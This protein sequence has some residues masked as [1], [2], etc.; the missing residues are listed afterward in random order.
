M[1][2][3]MMM[4]MRMMMMMMMMKMKMMMMMMV[5]VAVV[6]RVMVVTSVIVM[7]VLKTHGDGSLDTACLDE[8]RFPNQDGR[9]RT[10]SSSILNLNTASE[11]GRLL[12]TVSFHL[13]KQCIAYGWPQTSRSFEFRASP[14]RP[15]S[16]GSQSYTAF[17]PKPGSLHPEPC[18]PDQ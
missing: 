16:L 8:G 10:C 13:C 17:H 4:L 14:A 6:V 2:M 1:I 7:M 12:L 5:V 3:M 15:P 11:M 18:K 9:Q